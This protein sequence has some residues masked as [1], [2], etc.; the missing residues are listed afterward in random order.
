[1]TLEAQQALAHIQFARDVEDS[2]AEVKQKRVQLAKA[3]ARLRQAENDLI[4]QELELA[5]A[6]LDASGGGAAVP[7]MQQVERCHDAKLKLY[8]PS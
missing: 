7:D 6:L 2:L 1:M 3:L 8:R 4:Q 5:K